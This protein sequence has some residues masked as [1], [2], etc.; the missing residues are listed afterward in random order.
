MDSHLKTLAE[1]SL[2]VE[3]AEEAIAESAYGAARELL[4]VAEGH[5]EGLRAA[6]PQMDGASRAIVGKTAKS[7]AERVAAAA[8][9]IPKR[10][11][12]SEG[13]PEVDP[14]ED[15]EPGAAPVVTDRRG[16]DAG[17]PGGPPP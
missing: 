13:A 12:L 4:D 1:A 10:S 14:D 11:A 8:K 6:W 15:V 17:G 16:G 9:A 3:S 2:A 7:I 5:L